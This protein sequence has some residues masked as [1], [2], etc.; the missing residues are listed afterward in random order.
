MN[1]QRSG[2]R[3]GR[4]A[5]RQS[6]AKKQFDLA[7]RQW[8]NPYPPI[9]QFSA[10]EIEA[11]HEATLKVLR[12]IGIKVLSDEAREHYVRAGMRAGEEGVIY[13]DPDLVME[14]IAKAPSE[15]TM[16]GRGEGRDVMIGSNKVGISTSA[17]SPNC[18]DIQRGRRPGTL[19]DFEDFCRVAQSFDVIHLFGPVVEP[20]DIQMNIRHLKMAR[21]IATLT[22]KVPFVYFRGRQA[23]ADSYEIL[24]IANGL[25]PD[26]LLETP[27]CYSVANSNSPL[28][29]DDL[30]CKGIIDAANAG[31]MMILTPFTLAGAMAPVTIPGALVMQNAEAL[32]GLCLSQ[33]VKPG[34]KVC[35]GSFTSNVDMKSGAPAFGTPEYVKAAFASGQ[36]ARRY[37]LPLRSS[38][39][40]A[41]NAPD[42]QAAYESQMS[43]WGA[44]MGG[45][46]LVLHGAGWLEGG[47]TISAEKFIIDVEVLQMF[48]EIFK[49]LE[50]NE[51]TLGL[52]AIADVGHGGHFFGTQH[53]LDRFE[54]AFYSPLLSDW[55]N[56]ENWTDRGSADATTRASKI[57]KETL[58]NFEAPALEAS[59]L[60][61]IDDYITRR[62]AEGGADIEV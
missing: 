22:E 36:L 35:Y 9:E 16:M 37:G 13:F 56:F 26:Q 25:T 48:A 3:R 52:E 43:L 33:I 28:Q 55:D 50:V 10:D 39:P 62:I 46:N 15:F 21:A 8:R 51:A 2:G 23:V 29:L 38:G 60:D 54:T 45:A 6:N 53:T 59:R 24:R 7:W 11:I 12:D 41:S 58:Q 31:Q 17:G 49:P 57:F 1:S 18:S 14:L 27:V 30:M 19:Q 4:S 61:E 42:A 40:T 44:L 32:A 47:L 20:Q 5:K 34:A